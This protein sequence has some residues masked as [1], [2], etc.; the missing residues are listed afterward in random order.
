MRGTFFQAPIEIRIEIQ[1]EKWKQGD[2]VSGTVTFKNRGTAPAK[3]AEATVSL[4]RGTLKKVQKKDPAGID[5]VET[6]ALEAAG[7]ASEL[8]PGA[9]LT[10]PFS[11]K[12]GANAFVTDSVTSLFVVVGKLAAGQASWPVLQLKVEPSDIIAEFVKTLTIEHHFAFKDYR[13]TKN[14]VQAKLDPPDGQSYSSLEGLDLNFWFEGGAPNQGPE[15]QEQLQVDYN[16]TVK[17]LQANIASTTYKNETQAVTQALT[18][19]QYLTPS[20]RV[21]FEEIR[22]AIVGALASGCR[23]PFT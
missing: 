4:A 2:I 9:E 6:H 19:P 17:K 15:E 13:A 22:K 1:G 16:F 11:F 14:G 18:R 8:A 23:T 21:N 20:G 5:V 3:A 7:L 10:K 12:L